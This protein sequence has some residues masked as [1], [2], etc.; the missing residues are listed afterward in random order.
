M[1]VAGDKF[2]IGI[3]GA[4]A[5][6]SFDVRGRTADGSISS[7]GIGGYVTWQQKAPDRQE[8]RYRCLCRCRGEAGL[9][10]LRC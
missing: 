9:A 8:A 5:N 3:F 2:T 7:K 6:S 4:Y 1:F 10:R